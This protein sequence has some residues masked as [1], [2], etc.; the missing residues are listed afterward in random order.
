VYVFE[1]FE[2]LHLILSVK[3]VYNT[4]HVQKGN[5]LAF[6]KYFVFLERYIIFFNCVCLIKVSDISKVLFTFHLS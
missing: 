6:Q 3:L 4:E 1:E 2:K 5:V